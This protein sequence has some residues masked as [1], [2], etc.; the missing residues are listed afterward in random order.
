VITVSSSES[1]ELIAE[2]PSA[3]VAPTRV[4]Y[5]VLLLTVAAYMITYLDRVLLSAAVPSIQKELGFS[6]IT[7]GWVLG[8]YQI[9]YAVFQIPGGWLGDR[10]GARRALAGVVIWWSAFTAFTP[11]TGSALSMAACLFLFGMGEAG[12]F[13]IATRSLSRWMLPAERG[14]AQGAT[15]AGSRLG[16]ALTPVLAVALIA[17]F[18]WRMPFYTFALVGIVWAAGWY[19]F[20]RDTP[21]EHPRTNEAER[22]LLAQALGTAPGRSRS[23]PWRRIL[24]Q[25]QTWLLSAMYC[26]YGY[27]IGIFLTWFPKYLQAD[28]GLDL[29]QM[30]LYASLPLLAGFTGGLC[31]GTFSDFLIRRSGNLKLAR[32]AVATSGFVLTA[33]AIPLACFASDPLASIGYF[34]L[35]VFGLEL[36]V[37][38]SWAITLDI[39][40]EFAGSVSAVMNTWG[41]IGAT[42]A[43]AL[44]GYIVANSGWR[45]AFLVLAGLAVLAAILSWQIDASRRLRLAS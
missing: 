43:A 7:M 34:C 31:G 19:G 6:L 44:T 22:N 3:A 38:I 5:I 28:R 37:G 11:F 9:A 2:T 13:P 20:Y 8:S 17:H 30:G 1:S 27:D 35:A 39:G 15:H 26:C 16:G 14:F 42:A 36:T 4:R 10:L 29:H 21:G 41:N 45:A 25:P 18:G 23:V 40:G 24:S 33:I 12:A 32:R